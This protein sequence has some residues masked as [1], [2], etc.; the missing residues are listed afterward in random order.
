IF[1]DPTVTTAAVDRF[2]HHSVILELN[3]PS[4]RLEAAQQRQKAKQEPLETGSS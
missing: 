2:V 3:L 1:Q 4:Y